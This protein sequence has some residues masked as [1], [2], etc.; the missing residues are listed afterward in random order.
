M[1][2][3]GYLEDE[4]RDEHRKKAGLDIRKK[5]NLNDLKYIY[6]KMEN[7]SICYGMYC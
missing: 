2:E 4:L 6:S 1:N 7:K 5:I 3:F